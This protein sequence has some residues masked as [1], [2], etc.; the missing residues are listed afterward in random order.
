[1]NINAKYI[2]AGK[3]RN[4]LEKFVNAPYFRK[5]FAIKK[6]VKYAVLTITGLGY[7]ELHFNGKNITKGF[8]APY[9]SNP[10]DIVYFDRYDITK[11]LSENNVIG[12]LLGNG[13][14]NC[15]GGYIWDF[16]TASFRDV[17][18][19]CFELEIGYED[20]NIEKIS[21]DESIKTAPSPIIFDDLHYG[22]YYDARLAIEGWNLPDFDDSSWNNAI[23]AKNP[24]GE[25]RICEADPIV[26]REIRKPVCVRECYGGYIYDFGTNEAG[27]CKLKIRDSKEGQKILMQHFEMMHNG[28]PFFDNIRF[29]RNRTDLFQEDIYYCAGKDEETYM[30]HFT[31]HGF[32]YVYVTGITG[33][34]ATKDLLTYYIFN[35]DIKQIGS[36]SCDNE[37]VNKLQEAT[38][39]SD[40]SNFHYYPTD[41]PHREK[42]GWTADASLSAEQMLLNLTPENSYREWMRNI[43]KAINEK[44]QLPG[45]VP[46]APW[47]YDWGNGP[48]W[49]NVIVNLPYY[50]YIYRGDDSMFEELSEPLMRYLK[51]LE[52]RLD[53]NNLI[54]IGLGD[55]CQPDRDENYFTTPL[56]VTDSILTADIANKA[57]FIYD[58]LEQNEN[59][60]FA[61]SLAIKVTNAIKTHLIDHDKM[62]VKGDTQTGQ[63]MALY[64]GMFESNEYNQ[65]F[66]HLLKLIADKN[67]HF[68]T[69]V[70]GGRV[71]FRVL[72]ENGYA[73]LALKMIIRPDFPSFGNWIIKGSTTL[74]EDFRRDGDIIH[75]RNHHFWGDIS[76]WFYTYLAGIRINPT[77]RNV[78]EVNIKPCFVNTLNSV[79]AK[80][81]HLQGE[82]SIDWK[83]ANGIITLNVKLP[84]SIVGKIILPNGKE[85]NVD[86]KNNSLV[87]DNYMV[88]IE[89]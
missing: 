16:D 46:A 66:E 63:A 79:T 48:A 85:F 50:T 56:V 21:S 19:I 42:N 59:A 8:L 31:Y 51:Y 55:W 13:L 37:I 17:P 89:K 70:L 39:R 57:S 22:E 40:F 7:Y 75:S 58:V 43:Y 65:A 77:G 10:D 24:L 67:D 36:F 84:N 5:T 47:S 3:E 1:M 23:I 44:G 72:A 41:C 45:T 33:E 18:K 2:C 62:T 78:N 34:Q 28:R 64:Y 61:K 83:R 86:E 88:K 29:N 74:W 35:S 14:Q 76:A 68:D 6:S 26:V 52:T 25:E 32:R 20:G 71:I 73:D 27:V 53:E 11:Q 49:D 87:S 69:G 81:H 4:T 12:V 30:P 80:H 82:I 38:V 15:P 54:A 60:S 9:R